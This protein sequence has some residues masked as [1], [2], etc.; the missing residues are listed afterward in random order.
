M[1]WEGWH[2][3]G[4]TAIPV[5]KMRGYKER[6]ALIVEKTGKTGRGAPGRATAIQ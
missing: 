2:R 1:R 5:R 6:I 3:T 4:E